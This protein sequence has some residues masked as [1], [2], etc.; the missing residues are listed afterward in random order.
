MGGDYKGMRATEFIHFLNNDL[1]D[2]ELY[3]HIEIRDLET[4]KIKEVYKEIRKKYR[5][6]IKKKNS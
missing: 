2:D 3:T 6:S 5:K 1:I 4:K